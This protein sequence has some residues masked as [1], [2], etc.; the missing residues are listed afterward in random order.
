MYLIQ[1]RKGKLEQGILFEQV[2][3]VISAREF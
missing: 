1:K 3:G 2:H